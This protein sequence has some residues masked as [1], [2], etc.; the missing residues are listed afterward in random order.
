MVGI[1]PGSHAGSLGRA[2]NQLHARGLRGRLLLHAIGAG[3]SQRDMDCLVD[4]VHG[5]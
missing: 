5:E 2:E 1:C 4:A 3:S